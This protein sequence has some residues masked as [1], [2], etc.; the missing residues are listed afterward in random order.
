M[1]WKIRWEDIERIDSKGLEK[2][3]VEKT[4]KVDQ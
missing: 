1:S 4:N 2:S 3:V